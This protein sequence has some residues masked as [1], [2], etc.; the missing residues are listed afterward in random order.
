MEEELEGGFLT[1]RA[2]VTAVKKSFLCCH[3]ILKW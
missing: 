3:V 1:Y 2:V